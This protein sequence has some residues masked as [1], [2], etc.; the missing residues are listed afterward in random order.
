MPGGFA[1]RLEALAVAGKRPDGAAYLGLAEASG[2]E[3][4]REFGLP[5]WE[6]QALALEAGV[7][8]QRYVRNLASFSEA[9]QARLLRSRALLVGL[10]GLGG[11][12]L[13]ALC[14]AG[15]GRIVAADGDRFEESNLN[16]QLL[17]D[18]DTLSRPKAEAAA[19]R[20]WEINPAVELEVSDIFLD[21]PAMSAACAKVDVVVDA[22]G[23]LDDRP[24]LSRA[25]AEAGV[26]LVTAAIAGMSG[27]VATVLPGAPG[28]ASLFGTG[29]GA[30]DTLGSPA[31]SVA[32][33]ANLQASEALRI[34]AGRPPALSGHLLA[35]DLNDMT[36]QHLTIA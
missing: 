19:A 30:E 20:A 9:E 3:L 36:F 18:T 24:A 13:E 1:K 32:I 6:A 8:P 31:P 16:R 22:L 17:S 33:A 29:A 27:Y 12:V 21:F 23:G 10:G 15:V 7:V 14:R 2:V 28:P 25:A 5:L 34:L 26:P 4:A 11:Y 35:F